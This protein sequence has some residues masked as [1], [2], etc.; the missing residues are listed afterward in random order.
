MKRT[1]LH[2]MAIKALDEEYKSGSKK[3]TDR[4]EEILLPKETKLPKELQEILESFGDTPIGEKEA[5]LLEAD[6]IAKEALGKKIS[7]FNFIEVSEFRARLKNRI[8]AFKDDKGF[9]K[10]TPLLDRF[11][12]PMEETIDEIRE[13]AEESFKILK[14]LHIKIN[15]MIEEEDEEYLEELQSL[16]KQSEEISEE[17]KK[18]RTA[19]M[20]YKKD[21]LSKWEEDLLDEV[22]LSMMAATKAN[23]YTNPAET[24][25]FAKYLKK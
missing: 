8:L 5:K 18:K 4:I 14:E 6:D 17:I 15:D 20:G 16:I 23:S 12:I 22:L 2:T 1:K 25:P 21:E 11:E 9:Y 24:T 3:I 10:T 19:K 7:D 13:E